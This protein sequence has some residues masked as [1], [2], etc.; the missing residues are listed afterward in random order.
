MN[1]DINEMPVFHN[2]IGGIL[3]PTRFDH[4]KYPV[5]REKII[6]PPPTRKNVPL[7]PTKKIFPPPPIKKIIR[8]RARPIG[9][10]N[11]VVHKLPPRPPREIFRD[12]ARPFEKEIFIYPGDPIPD[13]EIIKDRRRPFEEEI[14][15]HPRD[16][17]P[18]KEIIRDHPRP[19]DESLF[20]IKD[21]TKEP[22]REKKSTQEW[23]RL[24]IT[25][26]EYLD[27]ISSIPL[28]IDTYGKSL[29]ELYALAKQEPCIDCNSGSEVTKENVQA[30]IGE[31]HTKDV[32]GIK[33]TG[34][35]YTYTFIGIALAGG[36]L[37][38]GVA[39]YFKQ[40]MITTLTLIAAGL[41][42]ASSIA[43]KTKPPVKS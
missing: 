4:A 27:I 38:F 28:S 8:D 20:E 5:F 41:M 3:G 43:F 35:I 33:I 18:D 30:G 6:P 16:P 24:G 13:K 42:G 7:P 9:K 15:I 39:K 23:D 36:A 2:M 1:R 22:P 11:E 31:G 17:I 19:F 32:S 29:E 21:H 25:N 12:K 10:A 14:F 37:G 26:E 34:Y 40:S